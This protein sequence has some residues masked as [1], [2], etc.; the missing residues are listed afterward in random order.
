MTAA[1]EQR[2]AAV[3]SPVGFRFNGET[4]LHHP[5]GGSDASVTAVV[6]RSEPVVVE[7]KTVTKINLTLA[8]TVGL[9]KRDKF[10]ID[11]RVFF[12]Q[13]IGE[14]EAGLRTVMLVR[15]DD[16]WKGNVPKLT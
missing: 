2:F 8:S 11:A 10:T 16:E 15:D 6:E 1:Y 13:A 14:V 5:H 4:I 9:T 7:G 12:V 3:G